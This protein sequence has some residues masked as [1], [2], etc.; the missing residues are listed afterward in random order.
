VR[1]THRSCPKE[2]DVRQTHRFSPKEHDVRQAHRSCP[3][4]PDVRQTHRSCPKE[5]CRRLL[6]SMFGYLQVGQGLGCHPLSTPLF[7]TR[8]HTK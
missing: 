7:E 5:T 1:Q 8:P 2:P 3:K 4:E 6:S